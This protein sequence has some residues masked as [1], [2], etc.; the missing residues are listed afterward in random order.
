M[1]GTNA[2]LS[3][4]E[5]WSLKNPRDDLYLT[6]SPRSALSLEIMTCISSEAPEH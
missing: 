5:R 2:P 1:A 3:L 4:I 6:W